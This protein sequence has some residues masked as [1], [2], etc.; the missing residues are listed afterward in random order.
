M[1]QVGT[2]D[3][4]AVVFEVAVMVGKVEVERVCLWCLARERGRALGWAC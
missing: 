4:V 1:G 3:A 2:P